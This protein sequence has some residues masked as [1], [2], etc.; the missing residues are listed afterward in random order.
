MSSKLRQ[1]L[2][3][4]ALLF[5]VTQFIF[6]SLCGIAMAVEAPNDTPPEICWI[7][8]DYDTVCYVGNGVLWAGKE[9][10]IEEKSGLRGYHR[11]FMNLNSEI[12]PLLNDVY[13]GEK[14][15]GEY[16]VGHYRSGWGLFDRFG[17][18]VI[19]FE[20]ETEED[21]WNQVGL[22]T[23]IYY[24]YSEWP[25]S[26]SIENPNYNPNVTYL[27]SSGDPQLLYGLMAEDGTLLIDYQKYPIFFDDSVDYTYIMENDRCGLMK[28]PLK[29][30]TIS[31]WAEPEVNAALD[32]GLVPSR[33]AG[34]Y[35]FEITHSQMA[36]LLV[37]Y[38][39]LATGKELPLPEEH[40]FADTQD[41]YIEKAYAAGIVQGVG[42]KI[43]APDKVVTREQL[44]TMLYRTIIQLGPE[45][46]V[47]SS[48]STEYSD[49]DQVSDWAQEAVSVLLAKKIMNGVSAT[50]ISPK[51]YCSTEQAIALVYRLF[52]SPKSEGL[53]Q[54]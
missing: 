11:T 47:D 29:K 9:Y 26:V 7:N 38:T 8:G 10:V 16:I 51:V 24:E 42:E 41:E 52:T 18:T 33:C 12:I 15:Q 21:A 6:C 19:P 49:F 3:I 5:F 34:Y 40:P 37:R 48:I 32:V 13:L 2:T 35:T 25:K 27:P 1:P 31:P 53:K 36:A 30:D 46:T 14:F 23:P 39:E 44:A 4:M 22:T 28:N 43:F 50:Q 17:N 20:F 54:G 45:W